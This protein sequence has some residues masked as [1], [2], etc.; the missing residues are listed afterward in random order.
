MRC[1][2]VSHDHSQLKYCLRLA[3]TLIGKFRG[4]YTNTCG[5]GRG[6]GQRRRLASK[7][8]AC[9][10]AC[11]CCCCCYPHYMSTLSTLCQ[12]HVYCTICMLSPACLK[13]Y[14]YTD[15]WPDVTPAMP[16]LPTLHTFPL[17]S[18][19]PLTLSCILQYCT[20]SLY[21]FPVVEPPIRCLRATCLLHHLYIIASFPYSF[22]NPYLVSLEHL[23][24]E[25]NVWW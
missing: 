8:F 21:Q 11:C 25:T 14:K 6:R 16:T 17:L 12:P 5:E 1:S 24:P 13:T 7:P 20:Q 22:P 18:L 19:P 9:C 4:Q 10:N 3:L 15:R 2:Y 23:S